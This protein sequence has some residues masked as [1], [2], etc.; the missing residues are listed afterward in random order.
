MATH[1]ALLHQLER[2]IHLARCNPDYQIKYPNEVREN[3][4]KK[5]LLC[6]H[7]E[8]NKRI[9]EAHEKILKNSLVP[10]VEPANISCDR[11]PT[12]G[13]WNNSP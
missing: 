2:A 4:E 12:C 3:P 5:V 9:L 11:L 7:V 10:V 8:A 1:R 13:T 6:C